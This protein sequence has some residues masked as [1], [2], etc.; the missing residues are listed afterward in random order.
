ME[1]SDP[2]DLLIYIT[3]PASPAPRRLTSCVGTYKPGMTQIAEQRLSMSAGRREDG[4]GSG[5][6]GGKLG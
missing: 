6:P 4:I 1:T 3:D 5:D 2:L